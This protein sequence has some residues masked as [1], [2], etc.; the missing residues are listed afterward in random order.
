MS[1]DLDAHAQ[2]AP[3]KR[4][5]HVDGARKVYADDIATIHLRKADVAHTVD[6]GGGTRVE[7]S[8]ELP[9]ELIFYRHC[10]R[11]RVAR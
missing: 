11:R 10:I 7:I 8:A 9:A 2:R 3:I 6:P 5:D 4:L 1:G